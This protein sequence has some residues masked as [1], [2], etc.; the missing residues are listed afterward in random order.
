MPDKKMKMRCAKCKGPKVQ[1]AEW[2]YPN[3]EYQDDKG[4]YWVQV[5]SGDPYSDGDL[6]HSWCEDCE[7]HCGVEASSD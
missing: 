4:N 6:H 7:D 5:V 3:T 1:L 2:T